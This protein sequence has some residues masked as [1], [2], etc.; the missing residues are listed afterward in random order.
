MPDLRRKARISFLFGFLPKSIVNGA[1]S[2]NVIVP[3]S[4]ISSAFKQRK[5]VVFPEPE[6][7]KMTTTCPFSMFKSIPFKMVFSPKVL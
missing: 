4:G 3:C 7:P 1:P 6:G 2:S 5:K